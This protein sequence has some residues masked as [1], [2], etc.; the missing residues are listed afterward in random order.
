[1]F[2]KAPQI[3]CGGPEEYIVDGVNGVLVP[4]KDPGAMA[5]AALKLLENDSER[6]RMAYNAISI[7]ERFSIENTYNKF[8]KGILEYESSL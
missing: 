6:V 3:R 7:K 5:K 4:P 1:M 2:L 8:I